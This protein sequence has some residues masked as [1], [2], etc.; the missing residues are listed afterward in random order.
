MFIHTL[1]LKTDGT[2]TEYVQAKSRSDGVKVT[3]DKR[4]KAAAMNKKDHEV[5]RQHINSFHPQ[6]SHYTREHAPYR[7]YQESD[8]SISG[9]HS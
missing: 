5:I 9:Y 2:I 7:R 1:G 3:V 8:L 6:I 4:G